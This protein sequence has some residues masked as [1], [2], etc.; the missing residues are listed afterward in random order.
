[1][2]WTLS[3]AT[4]SGRHSGPCEPSPGGF[5][6]PV[7]EVPLGASGVCRGGEVRPLHPPPPPHWPLLVWLSVSRGTTVTLS[8]PSI[9]ATLSSGQTLTL[10]HA[11]RSRLGNGEQYTGQSPWY[12]WRCARLPAADAPCSAAPDTPVTGRNNGLQVSR[13]ANP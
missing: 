11:I 13:N 10:T 1:M 2:S 7:M 9:A 3:I 8:P 12:V 6:E 4:N 5:T